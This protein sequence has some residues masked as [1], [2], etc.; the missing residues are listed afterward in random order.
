MRVKLVSLVLVPLMGVVGLGCSGGSS[1]G[2]GAPAA[3]AAPATS[4]T[5]AT[6]P[7]PSTAPVDS[8]TWPHLVGGREVA[9]GN[10]S[11]SQVCSTCHGNDPRASAMRDAAGREV[12]AH[13]LWRASMMANAVRDPLWRAAVAVEIAATPSLASALE[14]KCM[15]CHAPMA[16]ADADAAGQTLAM[17]DLEEDTIRAQMALDGISCALCHQIEPAADV[18]A[19]FNG[20]HTLG[21]S[22]EI[23]GP[24]PAPF[25][26]PMNNRTGFLPVEGAHINDSALCA[27]CHTLYTD[28][29]RGD[30]SLTGGRLPEQTPYLEWEN[31]A[32]NDK[33]PVP[34]AQAASCQACHLP[35]DDVDGNPISTRIARDG[36]GDHP[37]NP[38]SPYGRHVFLGGNTLVP[39][40]LRDNPADLKPQATAAEFDDLIAQTR[41][42]LRNRTGQIWIGVPTRTGDDVS[43]PIQV[44]NLTGHKFPTGHPV[45]RAWLRVRVLNGQG[46]VVFASGEHDATG[47]IVD[48]S[49][50]PLASEAAGGPVQPHLNLITSSA[51]VQIYQSLMQDLNGDVT[52]LLLRGEGYLKDNRLLPEGW[53]STHPAAAETAPQGLGGDTDF[54]AGVDVVTYGVAAPAAAGPYSVEATLFYQP[55]SARFAAEMFQYRAPEI[56]AFKHYY[57]NADTTPEVVDERTLSVP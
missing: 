22:R 11:S 24:Y 26:S 32:F 19:T 5:P 40:I 6:T 35:T 45:R 13:D 29:A 44:R 20:R 18:T 34:G 10:F 9:N 3:T 37:I 52:F 15:G 55:L 31:S 4:G 28:A 27:S 25:G 16:R 50:Q 57:E 39:A 38:R 36:A 51:E 1:G 47:R 7:P 17:K 46:Q 48:S 53:S 8:S 43:I 23:Y 49:G 56:D 12:G 30:G 41:D 33:V 21:Q 2:G 54:T 42:Q 14:D